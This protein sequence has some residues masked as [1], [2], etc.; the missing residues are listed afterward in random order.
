M[1][2][3]YREPCVRR[4]PPAPR[5]GSGSDSGLSGEPVRTDSEV[6]ADVIAELEPLSEPHEVL[7]GQHVAAAA[8]EE[9]RLELGG[10]DDRTNGDHTPAV[11][12][13]ARDRT[14]LR[15]LG[16]RQGDEVVR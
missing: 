3:R 7:D 10:A 9:R 15:G 6:H 11:G 4:Y 13:E 14:D 8:R 16:R 1:A 12:D 2:P 5:I